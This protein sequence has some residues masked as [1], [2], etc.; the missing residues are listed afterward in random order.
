MKG[1]IFSSLFSFQG[2]SGDL[3]YKFYWRGSLC[4]RQLVT[5]DLKIQFNTGSLL[6]YV[7]NSGS[8]FELRSFLIKGGIQELCDSSEKDQTFDSVSE[9]M[10]KTKSSKR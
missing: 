9:K 1:E 10:K 5:K 4:D 2:L 8:L 3:L 6:R 7:S